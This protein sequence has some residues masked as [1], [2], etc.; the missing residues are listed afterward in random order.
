[1][2]RYVVLVCAVAFLMTFTTSCSTIRSSIKP[3]KAGY[4]TEEEESWAAKY[5]P[6]VKAVSKFVPPPSD[7]RREWDERYNRWN[8][9]GDH[10]NRYPDL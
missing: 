10:G 8:N 7:A 9:Q 6:G 2:K 3:M 4:E 1:M 5:I